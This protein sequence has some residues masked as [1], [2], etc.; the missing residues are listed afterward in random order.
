MPPRLSRKEKKP[1]R[2]A[3]GAR[4]SP[5]RSRNYSTPSPLEGEGWG[6]GRLTPKTT[7]LPQVVRIKDVIENIRPGFASGEKN[8]RGGV[9]HLRMNNIGLQ[10]ELILDLVR[11]VPPTLAKPQYNLL[12]GD[13][14]VCTTNSGKL[15]GKCA[16][17]NL[18]G[19]YVF[20]NHLTRLRPKTNIIDAQ[21]LR[22]FLWRSWKSGVFEDKCKHWVNQST[23]PRE[24]LLELSIPMPP[25]AEQ[26]R[27]VAKLEKLLA[28]VEASRQR[29]DKIPTL[30]K[31]LRQT[32]LA[33]ACSG[34]LTAEWRDKNNHNQDDWKELKLSE[35]LAEPLSNGHSVVN[36]DKGFPVLRLTCLKNG[37][38]DLN[39]RKIGA[40]TANAAKRY[41]VRKGDYFVSR[42]NGSLSHVGRGGLIEVEPDS[43]AFPDTLIRVR[44]RKDMIEPM[45]L[46]QV[47]NAQQ[48]R[49]QIET[50]AHT[51]AGIWKISQ[52][53]IEGFV[54]PVP[55]LAEQHE[56]V[57]R[58][59][60]L[61]R[62]AVQIE[63]RYL[64][65]KTH[66]ETISQSILNKAFHGKLV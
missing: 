49:A 1:V 64:K 32:I 35:L 41:L 25:L 20:S 53:D 47:W 55:P 57:R 56:I 31:R 62:F 33:T 30:L 15:V 27:I 5:P 38:I 45:F 58:V 12:P 42:G 63:E 18:P 51:T 61:F 50:A 19:R 3:H 37:K 10:G 14:L 29:L 36:A 23:I 2:A 60:E 34:R 11:M 66:M 65:V 9:A 46:Q 59:E 17:F 16:Y 43:V 8:V 40:W 21:F 28:R 4:F 6:E 44:V 7:T 54:L 52:K 24:I 39:E 48:L 13:V 22:W 26:R